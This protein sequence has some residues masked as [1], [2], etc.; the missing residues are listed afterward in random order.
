MKNII[1]LFSILWIV[2]SS[3]SQVGIGTTNPDASSVLDISSTDK[4]ILVPRVSLSNVTN[5]MIDGT[6]TAATGLLI[7]NTNASV[8]GGNGVGFYFLM[9]QLGKS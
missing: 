7:Y 4:G 3:H 2:Q 8:T 5:T 1:L 9:E 6:N